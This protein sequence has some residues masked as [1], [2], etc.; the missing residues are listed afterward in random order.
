M[1]YK[2]SELSKEKKLMS[3]IDLLRRDSHVLP[4]IEP[5]TTDPWELHYT[6][7]YICTF[8]LER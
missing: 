2:L 3:S 4:G 6:R 5:G 8:F 1:L 7:G